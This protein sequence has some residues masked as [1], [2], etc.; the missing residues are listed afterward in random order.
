M[1]SLFSFI[2]RETRRRIVVPV[3]VALTLGC[4][5][6]AFLWFGGGGSS[7]RELGADE[8]TRKDIKRVAK[9]EPQATSSTSETE[10]APDRNQSILD[11]LGAGATMTFDSTGTG[12][13]VSFPRSM[14]FRNDLLKSLSA[15]NELTT[16]TIDHPEM[17]DGGF[18][19]WFSKL[20][21]NDFH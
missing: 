4:V 2:D 11:L 9:V 20:R 21:F 19:L 10:T 1:S 3:A 14:T 12:S 16:L 18:P 13:A 15:V 8:G 7:A 5:M 17:T 6:G